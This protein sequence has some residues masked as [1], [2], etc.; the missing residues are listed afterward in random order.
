VVG[1]CSGNEAEEERIWVI[2]RKEATRKT[3]CRWVDNIKL[4]LVERGWCG[5]D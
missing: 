5:V 2:D 1:A 4:A 3:K